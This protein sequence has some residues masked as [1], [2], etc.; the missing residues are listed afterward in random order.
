AEYAGQDFSERLN[1][2]SMTETLCKAEAYLNTVADGERF[3]LMRMGYYK[4]ATD[5][6]GNPVLSE[7]VSLKDNFNA[8]K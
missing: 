1:K 5:K 4:K 2:E 8:K 6:D 3:Q 7:I